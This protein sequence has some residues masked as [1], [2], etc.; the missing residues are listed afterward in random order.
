MS[1]PCP[2]C[3]AYYRK[4]CE[5]EEL[6][7]YCAWDEPSQDYLPDVTLDEIHKITLPREKRMKKDPEDGFTFFPPRGII[8][9]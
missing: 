8:E 2:F 4:T 9:K 7:G 5:M 3:G 1:S 6:M